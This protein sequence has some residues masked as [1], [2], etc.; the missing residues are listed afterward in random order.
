LAPPRRPASG[1]AAAGR[2][3]R[4]LVAEDNLVNQRLAIRLLEKQGHSVVVACNGQEALEA[5]AREP[6]DAVLMDVQMPEMGG[7][8]ATAAIR[9]RE[10]GT[11]NRVPIIAMTAHAMTGDRERCLEAGMD[12]YVAKPIQAKELTRALREATAPPAALVG[13]CPGD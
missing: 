10:A 1:A 12:G 8:E 5:L 9:A 13:A 3:L 6:F 4:L 2:P 11:G 7:L